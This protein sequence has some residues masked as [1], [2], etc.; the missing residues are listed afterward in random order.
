VRVL[1]YHGRSYDDMISMIPGA[2]YTHPEV[3]MQEMLIRRNLTCTYGMRTP[4]FPTK[5]DRMI[6]DPIPEIL[7]TGHVHIS[8]IVNYRGVLCVNPGT[9]Q[10]QTSFQKQMNIQPTPAMAVVVDLQT[11]KPEVFDFSG[12]L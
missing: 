12:D 6:I 1:L 2:T 4:I 3:M 8:G 5:E 7:L 10:S 9:W 11:M